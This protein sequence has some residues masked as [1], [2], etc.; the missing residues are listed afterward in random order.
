[1]LEGATTAGETGTTRGDA[2]T[3]RRVRSGGGAAQPL[4]GRH[5]GTAPTS[6]TEDT[7]G[8]R[9]QPETHRTLRPGARSPPRLR[10]LT[11]GRFQPVRRPPI[12]SSS[13]VS[14]SAT[15]DGPGTG[16][17]GGTR[18]QRRQIPAREERTT[19]SSCLATRGASW[20]TSIFTRRTTPGNGRP[21]T[22]PGRTNHAAPDGFGMTAGGMVGR[23]GRRDRAG[24]C[25]HNSNG[26]RAPLS[27]IGPISFSSFP[28][29][30]CSRG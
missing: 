8:T 9:V 17:R 25:L 29:S 30:Y 11:T 13:P 16:L 4:D 1:M 26:L 2:A 12:P 27:L 10:S 3:M 7:T 28:T 18:G 19:P 5:P 15:A 20:T 6:A 24:D 23:R 22:R 21:R 14:R